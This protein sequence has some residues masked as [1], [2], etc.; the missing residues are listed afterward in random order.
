MSRRVKGEGS[1]G[2]ATI[3]GTTYQRF[4][5]TVDGVRKQFYGRTKTEAREKYENYL[6]THGKAK[7][8]TN[9]SLTSA[10]YEMLDMKRSQIKPTTYAAYEGE[11]KFMSKHPVG[12]LQIAA[13]T[14][15]DVQKYL[16]SLTEEK[17]LKGIKEQKLIIK[18]TLD[19]CLDTGYITEDVMGKVKIP[20]AV[21]VK[22][23]TRQITFLTTE[24][25]HKIEET[26]FLKT[27][28][29]HPVF[30]GNAKYAIVFILHTGLRVSELV[31]LEWEDYDEEKRRI[32][33]SKNAPLIKTENG[34]KQVVTT[35]KTKNSVRNIPLDDTAMEIINI[36]GKKPGQKILFPSSA[37]TM[38]RQRNIMRTLDAIVKRS[39]IDKTP[40]LHDLRHTFA[41]ELIRNGADIKTVSKVLGHANVSTTLDIYV[42]KSDED[43]DKI[44]GL[45]D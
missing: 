20:A 21:H 41:S 12:R 35:P 25:R 31:A 5:I 40:T 36:L 22:K 30:R 18:M 14:T 44:R 6:K 15:K 29:G 28:K 16:D 26:A 1:W 42:H 9:L 43:I 13:I 11:I 32:H 33:V 19:Y 24:E 8:K 27:E 10:A 45:I 3:N 39:G 4:T 38:L 17:P 34:Y 7:K 37:G 2:P 23:P